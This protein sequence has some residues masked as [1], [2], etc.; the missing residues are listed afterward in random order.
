MLFP[1]TLR[2]RWVMLPDCL[3]FRKRSAQQFDSDSLETVVRNTG[4]NVDDPLNPLERHLF[5]HPLAGLLWERSLEEGLL[6]ESLGKKGTQLG[7]SSCSQTSS[8]RFLS[9]YVDGKKKAGRKASSAPTWLKLKKKIDIEEPTPRFDQLY[10]G[11][12][13]RESVTKESDVKINSDLLAKITTADTEAKPKI[14]NR[15]NGKVVT[16][17]YDMRGHAEKCVEQ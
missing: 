8:T 16:W 15:E 17:S 5:V 13:Q 12:T 1:H 10:S 6:Q 11:C 9:V 4:D 7:M 2:S 3:T 14:K